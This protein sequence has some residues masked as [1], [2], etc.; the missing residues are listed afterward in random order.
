MHFPLAHGQ[1]KALQ[2]FLIL[3]TGMEIL[4]FQKLLCHY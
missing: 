3:Y 2:D 4:D 1:G